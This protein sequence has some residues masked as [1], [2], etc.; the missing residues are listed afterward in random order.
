MMKKIGTVLL[1]AC[2]PGLSGC[3]NIKWMYTDKA[4]GETW[5]IRHNSMSSD[6]INY[7]QPQGS[8]PAQCFT[9]ELLDGPPPLPQTP[10]AS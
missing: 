5:W 4:T 3:S 10:P 7:C 8:G 9:A 6:E 1:F 2:L